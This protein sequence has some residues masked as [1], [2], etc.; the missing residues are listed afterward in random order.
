MNRA[1]KL[2]CTILIF[3]FNIVIADIKATNEN[4]L[5][6]IENKN[7]ELL[8]SAIQEAKLLPT[9]D[10]VGGEGS[11][12]G[13]SVSIYN[14]IALVG[15]PEASNHGAVYVFEYDGVAW[16]EIQTLIPENISKDDY[17]GHAVSI[18]ENKA[19]IGAYGDDENGNRSGSAYVYELKNGNWIQ[20]AKLVAS[21]GTEYDY[22][23]RSVSIYGNYAIVGADR[24]DTLN[25]NTGAVYTFE[26]INGAWTQQSKII[27]TLGEYDGYFGASVYL[28]GN[29]AI[30]GAYGENE[31]SGSVYIFEL[32]GN[33][34]N[35]TAK[36]NP[37]IVNV[38][39]RF[40]SSVSLSGDRLLIGAYFDNHQGIN[41]GSAYVFDLIDGNWI[42]NAIL[43]PGD[44]ANNDFFGASLSLSNNRAIIGSYHNNN[45]GINSGS[46]YIFDLNNGNWEQTQKINNTLG[47]SGDYFGSTVSISGNRIIIGSSGEDD[48]GI[49]SGTSYIYD[50]LVDNWNMT[51]KLS[52]S[53]SAYGDNFSNSISILGNIAL[54]GAYKDDDFGIDSGSAYIFE[55]DGESW[56]LSIKLHALDSEAGNLFGKEV[57]LSNNRAVIAANHYNTDGDEFG[58]VYV[59]DFIDGNWTQSAKLV[60]SDESIDNAFGFSMSISDDTLLIGASRDNSDGIK[61]GSAYIFNY[62]G[63]SWSET[64]KL[65]ASGRAVDDYFGSSVGILN[66]VALIGAYGD[67][68]NGS[69]S[70]AVYYFELINGNWLQKSKIVSSDSSE[71]DHFGISLSLTDNRALISASLGYKGAAY[72]FDLDNNGDWQETSKLRPSIF[73]L[74]P[75]YG[76][77][78]DLDGDRAIV[79]DTKSSGFAYVFELRNDNWIRTHRIN[80]HDSLHEDYFAGK[81]SISNNQVLIGAVNDDERGTDSGVAHV[82]KLNPVYFIGGQVTGLNEGEGGLYLIN[83]RE[84]IPISTNG[85]FVFHEPLDNLQ[86]YN[87]EI[88]LTIGLINQS[89]EVINGKGLINGS[90]I[91]NI[92]INCID[93]QEL[94]YTNGF[95]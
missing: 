62:D 92:Q 79:G 69:N 88:H 38:N 53:E 30:I 76:Y 73:G 65:S 31:N 43:Y 74:A 90:D 68:D 5:F 50:L 52:P 1:K 67:D 70:G 49:D 23:G 71:L 51:T 45:N 28:E 66:N 87:V 37:K 58:S 40:G 19:V 6:Q 95:E 25:E 83:N 24:N 17:F 78:V 13:K 86:S 93:I 63:S 59:F 34:W 54:I 32:N 64:T 36:I 91:N 82:F 61:S 39:A 9:P 11:F 85:T 16:N 12:F 57:S 21:D 44:G 35:Q 55:F 41:S 18:F 46:A 26:F 75:T 47:S 29:R 22:F 94:I 72:I 20:T 4:A 7:S 27:S 84:L 42:Q 89:C 80:L 8:K 77:S 15:S 2:I 3:A 33:N 81:V 60:A 48:N 56:S 10:G 14:N